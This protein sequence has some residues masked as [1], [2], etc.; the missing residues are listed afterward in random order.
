MDRPPDQQVDLLLRCMG[1]IE[2]QLKPKRRARDRAV[3]E[4]SVSE[5][6]A[7]GGLRLRGSLNMTELATILDSPISTATRVVDRLVEKGLVERLRSEKDRRIVEV[8][9]SPLGREINRHVVRSQR[10]VARKMLGALSAVNRKRLL[11]H[12]DKMVDCDV[13]TGK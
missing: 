8:S 5:L 4:C 2:E 11:G 6:R 1:L 12:L 9:F 13:S 3:P 10:A 7:L